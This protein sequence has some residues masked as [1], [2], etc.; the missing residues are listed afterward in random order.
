MA[1]DMYHQNE[2]ARA[3]RMVVQGAS[4]LTAATDGSDRVHVTSTRLFAPG[5]AVRLVDDGGQL[6]SHQ[7]AERISGTEVRL[8]TE[9]AGSFGPEQGAVLQLAEGAGAELR[10]VAIGQPWLMPPP[11][12]LQLPAAVVCPVRMNQPANTGTNRMY[13]QEY[14][15]DVYYLRQSGEGESADE[16]LGEKVASIFNLVMGDPYLSETCW[17]AQVT[18]VEMQGRVAEELRAKSPGLQVAR[19]GVLAKRSELWA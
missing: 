1:V 11:H 6:E 13:Q 4:G 8:W 16:V 9:V 10:W 2:I 7:V 18:E 19:I 5:V 3:L 17:H 14:L 15:L 12:S